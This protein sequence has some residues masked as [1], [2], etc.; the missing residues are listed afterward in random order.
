M[1]EFMNR[2]SVGGYIIAATGLIGL[3]I[4]VVYRNFTLPHGIYNT[5]VF[6]CLLLMA[7]S[8]IL[9]SFFNTKVDSYV[10][11]L[12][13]ALSSL[14]L[15]WFLVDCSGTINDYLNHVVFMGSGASI[16]GIVG[17]A[18]FMGAIMLLNIL[19]CFLSNSRQAD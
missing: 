14:A 15:A 4:M 8:N 13:V 11:I 7:L 19:S 1:K 6:T 18:V 9:L 16:E 5:S 17:I 2:K 3:V 10:Q 12:S